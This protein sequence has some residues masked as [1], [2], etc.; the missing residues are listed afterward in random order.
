MSSVASAQQL[1][2]L[3]QL[4]HQQQQQ[5]Q[6]QQHQQ[7]D[8]G[9]LDHMDPTAVAVIASSTGSWAPRHFNGAELVPI[10]YDQPSPEQLI[11]H[12]MLSQSRHLV[13]QSMTASRDTSANGL[14][15]NFAASTFVIV[16]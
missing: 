3:Q 13:L 12:Q 15:R 10:G 4:Q 14:L 7:A 8:L 5:Q 1:Q 2:Q 9:K 11:Q 16:L 6:Q